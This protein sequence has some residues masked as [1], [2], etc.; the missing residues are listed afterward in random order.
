[1]L[2]TTV[3]RTLCGRDKGVSTAAGAHCCQVHCQLGRA[4]MLTRGCTSSAGCLAGQILRVAGVTCR[5]AQDR[6]AEGRGK[7]QSR[8]K[9]VR[10]LTTWQA[11]DKEK[12]WKPYRLVTKGRP[13]ILVGS[14]QR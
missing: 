2:K 5:A 12:A 4:V 11:G 8:P 6:Q 3:L 7:A 10:R 9:A 1:M 14:W 13:E